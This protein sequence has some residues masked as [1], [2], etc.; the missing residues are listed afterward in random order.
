MS[1]F[2]SARYRQVLGNF[3]TGVTVVTADNDGSPP[4]G[5]TIGSFTSVSLDPPLVGFLPQKTSTSWPEI[6]RS[7]SF[8]VNIL[9]ADQGEL[10][11]RFAKDTGENR[12]LGVDW[13]R[14]P[15]GSPILVGVIGWIDCVVESVVDAGDHW[16]VLGRV[17]S[18]DA[19]DGD[20]MLFFRGKIGGFAPSIVTIGWAASIVV[21]AVILMA[22]ALKL[23]DPGWVG[24]AV[25]Y[26]T[27]RWAARVLPYVEVVLGPLVLLRVARLVVMP[28]AMLLLSA[29]T[30][31]LLVKWD[32]RRGE[33]CDCFGAWSKR[34]VSAWTIGRNFALI[35]LAIVA[36]LVD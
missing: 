27:P 12:F 9:A 13:H 16:F 5:I 35:A 23:R 2:D 4:V 28:A 17:T 22:G 31:F 3:A 8:C 11:W 24:K 10:C 32:E 1:S 19:H 33:P 6:E 25:E 21:G 34:P 36:G 7:G 26:G 18:L 30:I 29:F 15:S 20:P 14:A